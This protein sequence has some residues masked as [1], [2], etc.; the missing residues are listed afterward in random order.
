MDTTVEHRPI[1]VSIVIP[2]KN[3]SRIIGKC[4]DAIMGQDFPCDTEIIVIDS[5]STDNTLEIASKYEAVKTI[6]IKPEEFG[7]GKTRNLGAQRAS[8]QYLVFLNADAVPEDDQWLRRLLESFEDVKYETIAGVFSRHLPAEDCHLYMARDLTASMPAELHYRTTAGAFDFMCFSTV[9]AAMPKA[10]WQ[11]FPFAD[12]IL[13]AE[14]Q[15]WAG[16]VLEAGMG[17]LYEPGSIVRHSHNYTPGQLYRSKRQIGEASGRFSNKAVALL[18]GFLLICGGMG[19]KLWG[20]LIYIFLKPPRPLS[21]G[22]KLV[23]LK[24]SLAARPA[25]FWGRYMGWLR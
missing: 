16:R 14:D 8:G 3:E 21:F 23:Q 6:S 24:H 19:L 2:A 22:Q 11:R 13:I 18:F 20:D 5:G 7:H 10:I 1:G 9:S 4:L 25:S 15:E 12:D 17:I